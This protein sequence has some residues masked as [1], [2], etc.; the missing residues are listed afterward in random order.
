MTI[1]YRLGLMAAAVLVLAA[2]YG[3]VSLLL[4]VAGA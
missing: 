4:I 1:R 2:G 3:I